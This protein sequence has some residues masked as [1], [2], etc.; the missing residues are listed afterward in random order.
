MWYVYFNKDYETFTK[1]FIVPFCYFKFRKE[2]E[3][4]EKI[5]AHLGS[6]D[7]NLKGNYFLNT[8]GIL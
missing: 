3:R 2:G 7:F 5:V 6:E 8:G 1:I 4:E